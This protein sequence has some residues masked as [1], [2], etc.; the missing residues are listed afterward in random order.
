VV[1]EIS[2]FLV[3]I[4][5]SQAVPMH[6]VRQDMPLGDGAVPKQQ[7]LHRFERYVKSQERKIERTVSDI[8]KRG[9]A[10][11]LDRCRVLA[12][13]INR[14]LHTTKVRQLL[15]NPSL[16]AEFQVAIERAASVLGRI[17]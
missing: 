9:V 2:A 11:A 6:A 8:E 14:E 17:A 12:D 10:G 5:E 15:D 3:P 4:S 7:Q 16:L 1:P 13:E